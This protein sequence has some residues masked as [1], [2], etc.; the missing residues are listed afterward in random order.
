MSRVTMI[1]RIFS[2]RF[3]I[4][5]S[6]KWWKKL[7]MTNHQ[8]IQWSN[9]STSIL[10]SISISI[11]IKRLNLISILKLQ[12][13]HKST[14]LKTLKTKTNEQLF[15]IKRTKS[16]RKLSRNKLNTQKN[17]WL[18]HSIKT[19]QIS[20]RTFIEREWTRF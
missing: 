7:T 1:S 6:T 3:Y 9:W 8:I 11:L 18:S 10:I 2:S 5:K 19:F 12:N 15:K 4:K 14:S 20:T 16:M 13:S 17:D